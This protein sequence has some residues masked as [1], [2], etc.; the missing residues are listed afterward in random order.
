MDEGI[1]TGYTIMAAAQ[2]I[3]EADPSR[4]VIAVPVAPPRALDRLSVLADEIVCLYAPEHFQAVGQFY[5]DFS[6]VSHEEVICLLTD[7]DI[8]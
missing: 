4:I 6:E 1:A 7:Q 8:Q 5:H 2:L 3:R